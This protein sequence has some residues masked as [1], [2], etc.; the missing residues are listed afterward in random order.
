MTNKASINIQP[1]KA[2]CERHFDNEHRREDLDYVFNDRIDLNES[3]I[4]DDL[5]GSNISEYRASLE[6]LAKEKTGRKMQKKASP[7][8][9]GVINLS[10]KTSMRELKTFGEKLNSTYGLKPLRIEIHEDEGYTNKVTNERKYNRHA[11][12]LFDWM[13]HDTGKSIK[14]N[15]FDMREIQDLLADTLNMER[16]EKVELDVIERVSNGRKTVKNIRRGKGKTHLTPIEYKD[17]KEAEKSDRIRERVLKYKKQ[18]F[19]GKALGQEQ[20]I[21][22]NQTLDSMVDLLDAYDHLQNQYREQGDEL[23]LL[24]HKVSG[25]DYKLMETEKTLEKTKE[26]L[27]IANLAFKEIAKHVPDIH[28]Q[29]KKR[30][31]ELKIS[32]PKKGP[33]RGRG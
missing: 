31:E 32:T 13:N 7:I 30:K 3:F 17:K 5:K 21:D 20:K 4:Y 19:I 6:Q 27:K 26:E 11:H 8:K 29:I 14:L 25:K 15:A 24:R 18:N 22:V 2:S 28:E 10:P 12:M 9:E 16:G 33:E 23:T 1:I